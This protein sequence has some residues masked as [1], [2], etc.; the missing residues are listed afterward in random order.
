MSAMV[1]GWLL[2]KNAEVRA[3]TC[4][5]STRLSTLIS[6]LRKSRRPN[7][8]GC[9]RR[10]YCVNRQHGHRPRRRI[11]RG[12]HARWRAFGCPCCTK[13]ERNHT[14]KEKAPPRST[15]RCPSATRR[16]RVSDAPCSVAGGSKMRCRPG[17]LQGSG[18]ADR[19][20]RF[21]SPPHRGDKP[22]TMPGNRDD[23]G[24]RSSRRTARCG[25]A[26][27]PS[28]SGWLPRRNGHP[29]RRW[30]NSSFSTT[31]PAFSTR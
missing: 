16:V 14:G 22:V 12:V 15:Q 3:A 5:A 28:G 25:A 4:S 29:T 7:S 30:S 26:R 31:R 17:L 11:E 8:P 9:G 13:G 2:K 20:P 18:C 10:S 6:F 19:R 21:G 23:E 27:T 1:A 24:R